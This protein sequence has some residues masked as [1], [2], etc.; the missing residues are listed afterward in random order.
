MKKNESLENDT[1]KLMSSLFWIG[2]SILLLIANIRIVK[3]DLAAVEENKCK[4]TGVK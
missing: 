1:L 4:I 2:G 3:A